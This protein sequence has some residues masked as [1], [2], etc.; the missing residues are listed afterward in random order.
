MGG[1]NAAVNCQANH[2]DAVLDEAGGCCQSPKKS[3]S[4]VKAAAGMVGGIERKYCHRCSRSMTRE[5]N[6]GS[7]SEAREN[8]EESGGNKVVGKKKNR[9]VS[10]VGEGADCTQQQ[11][12]MCCQADNCNADLYEAKRYHQ[13]HRVCESHAKAAVVLV[14]GIEQ[15]YC[16]QCSR[17]QEL[18]EFDDNKR[19]CR[20]RLTHHNERRRKSPLDPEIMEDP[21]RLP[22]VLKVKDNSWRVISESE[23][24]GNSEVV[25]MALPKSSNFKHFQ[26]R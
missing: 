16:Q 12:I 13:K 24:M 9:A 7:Q 10:S 14:G 5:S 3:E 18:S 20:K 8:E 1:D 4:L 22:A 26:I 17:F 11:L 2:G 15:R 23:D 19:S 6:A 25:K 21:G